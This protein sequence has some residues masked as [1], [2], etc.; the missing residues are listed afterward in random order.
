[1]S[2]GWWQLQEGVRKP[3]GV[4]DE[5]SPGYPAFGWQRP[6]AVATLPQ[7]PDPRQKGPPFFDMT[8][9]FT[10]GLRSPSELLAGFNGYVQMGGDA[11]TV[12][13]FI[14]RS[15]AKIRSL[16]AQVNAIGPPLGYGS[17]GYYE[18]FAPIQRDLQAMLA[19]ARTILPFAGEERAQFVRGVDAVNNAILR[20][21]NAPNT[22]VYLGVLS[23]LMGNPIL[24]LRP[25]ARIAQQASWIGADAGAAAKEYGAG[26]LDSLGSV[27]KIAAVLAIGYFGLKAVS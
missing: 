23:A 13:A 17:T 19:E 12:D 1:M 25:A 5:W 26:L 3:A 18:Q 6:Q 10:G 21:Q 4:P 9:A 24:M 14:E 11:E 7:P 27:A 22:D 16:E 8:S 15:Q 20:V 2:L